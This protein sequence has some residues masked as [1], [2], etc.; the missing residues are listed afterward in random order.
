MRV[1]LDLCCLKRPFDDKT[2]DRVRLE[3]EAVLLVLEHVDKGEITGCASEALIV[4]NSYNTNLER[5]VNVGRLLERIG[6]STVITQEMETRAESLAQCG[7][8]TL[9]ALHLAC[10]GAAR[11][12]VLLTCDDRFLRAAQRM[13][14]AL[15]VRVQNPID[16]LRAWG[17]GAPTP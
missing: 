4:E 8:K 15:P 17:K 7:F 5:R 16:F 11:A 12:D 14:D 3:A 2:Q 1:Y 9:D 13:V 10:A 6:R